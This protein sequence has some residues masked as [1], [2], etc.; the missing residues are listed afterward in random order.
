MAAHDDAALNMGATDKTWAEM[1]GLQPGLQPELA[2]ACAAERPANEDEPARVGDGMGWRDG[3]T[4][5]QTD[6]LTVTLGLP[7]TGAAVLL[8]A[9]NGAGKTGAFLLAAMSHA[10]KRKSAAGGRLQQVLIV[11]G[12][13]ALVEQVGYDASIL[14]RGCGLTCVTYDDK[15]KHQDALKAQVVVAGNERIK[16]LCMDA[17]RNSDVAALVLDECDC[18]IDDA[19]EAGL[20]ELVRRQPLSKPLLLLVTATLQLLRTKEGA[21]LPKGTVAK[22]MLSA[23]GG[24]KGANAHKLGADAAGFYVAPRDPELFSVGLLVAK[25]G[26]A[27]SEGALPLKVP[28]LAD[29]LLKRGT[30]SRTIVFAE[31][32]AL[33]TKMK[34]ELE[35]ACAA[36]L[37]GA[38][39]LKFV[40]VAKNP[41]K[42]ASNEEK[43]KLKIALGQL[44]SKAAHVLVVT[45]GFARGVDV[46][47]LDLVVLSDLTMKGGVPETST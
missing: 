43:K 9:L 34:T 1:V 30:D 4:E 44:R 40:E 16:K 33:V 17:N 6:L 23:V 45:A 18:T 24:P 13:N 26:A 10:L 42:R 25:F 47:G 12:V 8:H 36:R 21:D 41:E 22:R 39:P 31:T 27:T 14:A 2:K 46:K 3:P 29:L 5:C 32:N 15:S 20:T 37:G 7:T 28:W 38:C 19:T 35:A 11:E